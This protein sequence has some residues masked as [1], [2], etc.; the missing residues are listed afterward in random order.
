MQLIVGNQCK[1]A[2][3]LSHCIG[4]RLRL[5]DGTCSRLAIHPSTS[6]DLSQY[7]GIHMSPD[8]TGV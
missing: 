4:V 5:R 2:C 6:L 7:D 8:E 1:C 3:N